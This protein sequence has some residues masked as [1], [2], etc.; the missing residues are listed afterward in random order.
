LAKFAAN[1][2]AMPDQLTIIRAENENPAKFECSYDTLCQRHFTVEHPIHVI[3]VEADLYRK[4]AL[5]ACTLYF[6]PEHLNYIFVVQPIP[7][8]SLAHA[9]DPLQSSQSLR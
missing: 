2:R 4:C 7:L 9:I 5:A 6:R 3:A 8:H 1:R